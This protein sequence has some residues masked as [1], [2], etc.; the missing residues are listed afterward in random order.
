MLFK[1]N[2]AFGFV[3]GE[4]VKKNNNNVTFPHLLKQ[5]F[6]KKRREISQT[7]FLS[8]FTSHISQWSPPGEGVSQGL[9][10]AG[11]MAIDLSVEI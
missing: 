9:Q 4:V 7:C 1:Y 10:K 11:I 2:Y 5:R 3:G 8:W 6:K